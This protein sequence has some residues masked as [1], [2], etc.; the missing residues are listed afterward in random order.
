MVQR[1]V[2]ILQG[3]IVK[4]VILLAV[5]SACTVNQRVGVL[6]A[7]AMALT[8][9]DYRQTAT[10]SDDGR[11]DVRSPS[12]GHYQELNPLLG[13][14]PTTTAMTV[15]AATAEVGIV[16]VGASRLPTWAKYVALGLVA[17]AETVEVV[18]V[19]PVAGVC[20]GH[21]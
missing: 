14:E 7:G 17:A 18:R 2:P 6:A 3:L 16:A 19:A 15:Y 8:A 21:R 12:G 10:L 20:G 13:H 1:P 11:W 4:A 5:L 9:C